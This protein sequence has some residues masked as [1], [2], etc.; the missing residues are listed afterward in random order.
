[1]EKVSSF[2]VFERP[3]GQL[4]HTWIR[5]E[6]NR[7]VGFGHILR[8]QAL[9][10]YLPSVTFLTSESSLSFLPAGLSG[11]QVSPHFSAREAQNLANLAKPGDLLVLDSYSATVEYLEAARQLGLRTLQINDLPKDALPA[12]VV[13]NHCPGLQLA[14]FSV[15]LKT[16]YWL[17][18]EYRL[19]RSEFQ[20]PHL[21]VKPKSNPHLF[22]CFGGTDGG[23]L[24]SKALEWAAQLIPACRV[25]AVVGNAQMHLGSLFPGLT[26]HSNLTAAQMKA[27]MAECSLAWVPASTLALEC[28]VSGLPMVIGTTAQ[29]QVYL[30]RGLRAFS[31][32]ASIDSWLSVDP[33]ELLDVSHKMLESKPSEQP[34]IPP[35]Q[36]PATLLKFLS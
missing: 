2:E 17:G 23:D 28:L 3:K 19:L 21:E 36:L 32:V 24:A 12:D 4:P 29:N 33:H 26:L 1:M 14:D 8:C 13:L 7:T 6:G 18:L 15:Q 22:L 10:S 25:S 27:L 11:L 9:A 30:H 35:S 5:T 16:E 31:N 20:E 34:H